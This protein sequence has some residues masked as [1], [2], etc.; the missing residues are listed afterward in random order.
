M[1]EY[2]D[3]APHLL[4]GGQKQRIAIAGVIAMRP[5][6]IVLDEPT[7]MLDPVGR[8]DVLSIIDNLNKEH[9][10]TVIL[11]THHMNEAVNADRIIIMDSGKTVMEGT[12]REIFPNID[13]LRELSLNVPQTVELLA[14]LNRN[15]FDIPLDNIT[16]EDCVSA[17][18][19]SL[20]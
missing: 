16:I 14:E 4:S 10:I 12:P 8:R 5:R 1:Y 3:H 18:I 2:R 9:K 17:I 20:N 7:S 6:C 13:K 19:E 11:I 15:G